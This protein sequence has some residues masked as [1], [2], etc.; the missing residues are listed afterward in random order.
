MS[1]LRNSILWSGAGALWCLLLCCM[2]ATPGCTTRPAEMHARVPRQAVSLSAGE[3]AGV[4]KNADRR[5]LGGHFL[6]WEKLAHTDAGF[7]FGWTCKQYVPMSKPEDQVAIRMDGSRKMQI[8]LVRHATE[9]A[10]TTTRF[11]RHEDFIEL[12][13]SRRGI[14]FLWPPFWGWGSTETDLYLGPDGELWVASDEGGT[15]FMLI[16]PFAARSKS[17]CGYERV[18]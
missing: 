2:V 11:R 6:L 10:S 18:Q 3:F 13:K 4:Y 7:H 5:S 12:E 15:G 8:T 1:K 16:L 9:I 17:H 14:L